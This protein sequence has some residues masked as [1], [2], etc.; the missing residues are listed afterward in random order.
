MIIDYFKIST[1]RELNKL[2]HFDLMY[3]LKSSLSIIKNVKITEPAEDVMLDNDKVLLLG[4]ID[5]TIE[6]G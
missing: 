4:T 2:T 6:R 5:I 1:E 3:A